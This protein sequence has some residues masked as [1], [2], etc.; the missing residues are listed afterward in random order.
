LMSSRRHE[1]E[2]ELGRIACQQVADSAPS[3]IR[4]LIGGLGMGY[5]LRAS[6]DL[7]PPN[8]E[9]VVAELLADVVSWNREIIGHLTDHPLED[10][11]V[12]M[13]TRNVLEV[14]RES[15]NDFDAILLDID[16]GPEALSDPTNSEL[17]SQAGIQMILRALKRK[18]G[19]YLWSAGQVP[20]F[21]RRLERVGLSVE[22]HKV[23]AYKDAKT[24]RHYIIAASR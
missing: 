14:L 18:G 16:N 8:A 19:L 10:Q 17:Y 7:L 6:L 24:C 3:P 20:S 2:L 4:I 9:I 11:R 1:S 21:E 23:K 12:S 5:T 15:S 22:S 13:Q